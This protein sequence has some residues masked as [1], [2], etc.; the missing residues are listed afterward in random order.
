MVLIGFLVILVLA[1]FAAAGVAGFVDKQMGTTEGGG[2]KGVSY[3]LAMIAFGTV[4]FTLLGLLH[5]VLGGELCEFAPNV[6]GE[7]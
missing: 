7:C 1:G 6:F 3:V 2:S 4:L 5:V